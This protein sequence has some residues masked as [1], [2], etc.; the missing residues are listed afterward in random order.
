[1]VVLTETRE[2]I[3][4]RFIASNKS[5]VIQRLNCQDADIV[6]MPQELCLEIEALV[7]DAAIQ[8]KRI[9]ISHEMASSR[10]GEILQE[11]QLF[12]KDLLNEMVRNI[13]FVSELF[14]QKQLEIRLEVTDH[15]SC[16]KFHCDNVYT[17]MLVTYYGPTTEFIE[18][19]AP[20][21]LYHA[22]LHAIVLLKGHKHPTYQDRIL[23]R[24]P[25]FAAGDK[26]L[27]MIVNFS[28]WL[29]KK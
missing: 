14:G 4:A 2:A 21:I 1:M 3:E 22:P 8:D 11:M 17:R 24:S 6:I 13:D 10:I 25:Q 16:P 7:E 18:T 15:Q 20:D 5:E 23:H 12:N 28:D 27:C 9:S 19:N 26:R 29:P